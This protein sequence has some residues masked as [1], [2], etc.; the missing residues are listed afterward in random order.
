[1]EFILCILFIDEFQPHLLFG[2]I[3][4]DKPKHIVT[5][6]CVMAVTNRRSLGRAPGN[7]LQQALVDLKELKTVFMAGKIDDLRWRLGKRNL[8]LRTESFVCGV[9][10]ILD[11]KHG[12]PFPFTLL[13]RGEASPGINRRKGD[14][15]LAMPRPPRATG[16]S[17]LP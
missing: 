10:Q 3:K 13:N 9:I 12:F 11:V 15:C 5:I 7:D 1:M 2:N 17:I 16:F 6:N 8:Q 14:R 4:S